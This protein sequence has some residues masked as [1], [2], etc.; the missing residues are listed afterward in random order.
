[1]RRRIAQH[2]R[3]NLHDVIFLAARHERLRLAKLACQVVAVSCRHAARHDELCGPFDEVR[4]VAYLEN[5]LKAL[6]GCCLDE[7]ARIHDHDVG[8]GCVIAHLVTGRGQS[9]RHLGGVNFIFGATKRHETNARRALSQNIH[10]NVRHA[11]TL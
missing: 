2:A 6:F 11:N 8:R 3:K 9:F 10:V 4:Q 7:R 5:S 1:M